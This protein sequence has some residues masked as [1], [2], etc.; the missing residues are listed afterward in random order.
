MID[1]MDLTRREF[2]QVSGIAFAAGA[3]ATSGFDR[4]F[5]PLERIVGRA[6][7]ATAIYAAPGSQKLQTLL[8]DTPL[9]LR[10]ADAD[11]YA[12]ADGFVPRR[13]VQPMQIRPATH[14]AALPAIIEV[15]AP[16]AVVYRHA[17]VGA[18]AVTRIGHGGVLQ[19][20]DWL[21]EEDDGGWYR[22]ADAGGT[23]LGWTQ[24][25]RWRTV[26]PVAQQDGTIDR[27]VIDRGRNLLSASSEG[28]E[29]ASIAIAGAADQPAGRYNV[30]AR[31][32]GICCTQEVT[33][34][35][36]APWAMTLSNHLQIVGAYWHNDFGTRARSPNQVELAPSAARWLYEHVAADAAVEIV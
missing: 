23:P 36:G 7:R 16:V 17:D 27:I 22:V 2:L 3:L 11:W 8:P 4:F 19:A 34:F 31:A 12:T 26:D 15:G 33:A 28:R 5:P 6:L 1:T 18:S 9:K 35:Y 25:R 10:A 14:P 21:P 32:P 24:A 13:D 20:T 30:V 29:L